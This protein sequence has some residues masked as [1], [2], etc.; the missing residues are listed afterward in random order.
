MAQD[1]KNKRIL[2]TGSSDGLGKLLAIELAKLGAEMI[3][4][5]RN[6]EKANAV[7]D[8]L[9]EI[10]SANHEAIVCDLSKPETISE[11][12]KQI[13]KLDI[14]INNAGLWAEGDTIDTTPERII[15]MVNVNLTSYL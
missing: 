10:S 1:L 15:E 3:V 12:F 7:L 2:I 14:L 4:H 5:G 8:Q 13:T 9:K 11:A 6:S